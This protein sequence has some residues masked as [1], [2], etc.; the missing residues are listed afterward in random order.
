MRDAL[1]SYL[2]NKFDSNSFFITN[3]LGYNVLDKIAEKNKQNFVNIGICEQ[4][5]IGFASGVSDYFKN[6][7]VYSIGNFLTIRALEQIRNDICYHNKNITMISVGAGF[8]YSKLGYSHYC[9]EDAGLVGSLPN[10]DVFTPFDSY[11]LLKCLEH[12]EKSKKPN[13]IRIGNII[14][15]LEGK[16]KY[17]KNI[18]GINR[19]KKNNKTN[20]CVIS[21]GRVSGFANRLIENKLCNHYILLS[22]NNTKSINTIIKKY[23]HVCIVDEQV[24]RLSIV[25]NFHAESNKITKVAISNK[26]SYEEIGSNEFLINKYMKLKKQINNFL[27]L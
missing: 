2:E 20:K 21:I 18:F 3:D 1:K 6:T 7:F 26:N 27:K 25:N 12:C 16:V 9:I 23:K 19:M 5:A 4:S 8:S 15:N 14:E 24:E 13:Y 17:S 11:T 10:V 22:N